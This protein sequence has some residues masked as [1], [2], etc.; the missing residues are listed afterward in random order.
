MGLPCKEKGAEEGF[1]VLFGTHCP[2]CRVG[3]SRCLYHGCQS[4]SPAKE[5]EKA[6]WPKELKELKLSRFWM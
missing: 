1:C 3:Q 4:C 6:L 2:G 5:K